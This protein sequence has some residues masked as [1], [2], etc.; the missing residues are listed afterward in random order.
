MT[1]YTEQ[2]REVTDQSGW[3]EETYVE[4]SDVGV[5]ITTELKRGTGT[6]DQDKHTVKAKGQ[7]PEEAISYHQQGMSYLKETVIQESRELDPER[8][9]ERATEP[10][11]D[12]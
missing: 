5:S 8:L 12:T 3:D 11:E 9:P 10:K 7:T 2:E 6:R 1:D 4:R